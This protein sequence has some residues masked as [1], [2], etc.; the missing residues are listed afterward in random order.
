MGIVC[1]VI[2]GS[3]AATEFACAKMS[4]G[5]CELGGMHMR[6]GLRRRD[7]GAR[8]LWFALGAIASVVPSMAGAAQLLSLADVVERVLPG[9]VNI[10]THDKLETVK[11]ENEGREATTDGMQ[12]AKLDPFFKLFV[13]PLEIIQ[14]ETPRSRG[15]GFFYQN[16][17]FVVTNYHVVKDAKSIEVVPANEKW[18]LSAKLIGMNKQADLALLKLENPW[19]KAR[20][21]RFGQSARARIGEPVFAIGNPFGYGHTVTSG[22]LSA[23]GR[24][25]GEGPFDDFLQTDAAINPGNSGGPLFNLKGEVIG[26]N[27][28]LLSDA[29][30]ISFAIPTEVARPIL[31]A[32]RRP[33]GMSKFVWLGLGLMNAKGNAS[34]ASTTGLLVTHVVEGSPA[35]TAGLHASDIVL[36]LNENPIAD[37]REFGTLVRKLTPGARAVVQLLRDGKKV[38]LEV[39]IGRMPKEFIV[40]RNRPE[41]Y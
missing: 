18:G 34:E 2:G 24:T 9:V 17:S 36:A 19:L 39:M 7:G 1:H 11:A 31:D 32:L 35:D 40:G 4:L 6:V 38:K 12:A 16:S 8:G 26:I 23:K 33:V 3:D 41:V 15:S 14:R 10:R 21:L 28:A 30:G 5:H 20:P 22:I 29:R 27:T 37:V 13:S 25:I